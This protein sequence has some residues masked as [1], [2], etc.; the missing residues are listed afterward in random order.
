MSSSRKR[1]SAKRMRSSWPGWAGSSTHW[2]A[3]SFPTASLRARRAAAGEEVRGTEGLRRARLYWRD[4][5]EVM[6][7]PAGDGDEVR[8]RREIASQAPKCRLP[9]VGLALYC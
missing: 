2:L 5:I 9:Q 4:V 3:T 1:L 6:V 7:G 8:G